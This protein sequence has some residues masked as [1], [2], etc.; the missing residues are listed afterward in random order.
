M[1]QELI[2]NVLEIINQNISNENFGLKELADKIGISHSGLHR[3][4]KNISGLTISRFIQEVRLKKA[5][6]ILLNE[7][8]TISEIA[9]GTGF[10]SPAYFIKCFRKYYGIT[11]GEYRKKEIRDEIKSEN[12]GKNNYTKILLIAAFAIIALF[13]ILNL[14]KSNKEIGEYPADK[15]IAVS[16]FKFQ[17]DNKEKEYLP[18]AMMDAILYQLSKINDLKVIS[19][20]AIKSDKDPSA[21]NI[22]KR[23]GISF[24][25]EGSFNLDKG[26]TTL[27]LKLLDI[28]TSEILWS[29]SYQLNSDDILKLQGNV[30]KTVAN[31]LHVVI[32]PSE[33]ELIDRFPTL[34]LTAYDFYQKGKDEYLR[35][36]SD[37][38]N[39]SCLQKAEE[40]Y[41]TAV[42]YDSTFAMAYKGLACT[43]R[44]KYLSSTY[45]SENYL[46][47]VYY[48][49]N[50]ALRF[51]PQ[52]AEAYTIR[53]DYFL[54]RSEYDRAL[55]DY[56]KALEFNPNDWNTYMAKGNL[57]LNYDNLEAIKNINEACKLRRG[58]EYPVMLGNLSLV[59][60]M[61]GFMELSEKIA[62]LKLQLDDDSVFYF[63]RM[64]FIGNYTGDFEAAEDYALRGISIDSTN[65]ELLKRLGFIYLLKGEYKKSRKIYDS[66][67][68]SGKLDHSEIR[69][70]HRIGFAYMKTGNTET[71]NHYFLK[72][73][74]FCNK[75]NQL[76][77]IVSFLKFTNYDL[78]L[79]YVTLG[80]TKKAFE[81]LQILNKR[82][83]YPDWLNTLIK[84]DP[85]L[86]PVRNTKEF[87]LVSSDIEIKSQKEH[88][89][90]QNWLE[91]Q[92]LL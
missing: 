48:L 74:E 56:N 18:F 75:S 1:D 5:A 91:Q 52:L 10:T 73:I 51:D 57:Y 9:Y 85:M 53:G 47:T 36:F 26:K 58:P 77:R 2:N 54:A 84:C 79:V 82:E 63:G 33:N 72:E 90:I 78:A 32:T 46:D 12:T 15:S 20:S 3:K 62:L 21:K 66:Y 35:Y 45:Y 22:G 24:L 30:A 43:L 13:V 34:N 14:G 42:E 44:V 92:K 16:P 80:D 67:L 23:M 68:L 89:R 17:G 71:A 28:K 29:E 87:I 4:I 27:F 8:I 50:K 65:S 37:N 40:F 61:E 76:G 64:S 25:L 59:Y 81:N 55:I 41:T 88:Q 83:N 19:L 31:E 49:S 39:I 6:E 38:T 69:D 86:D 7:K 11:P 70:F 60:A